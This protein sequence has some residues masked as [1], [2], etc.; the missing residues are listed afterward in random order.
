MTTFTTEDRVRALTEIGISVPSVWSDGKGSD[1]RVQALFNPN[2]E[3]DPHVEYINVQTGQ[4][5][6]CRLPAFKARFTPRPE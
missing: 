1:F 4:V 6:T 5:Y 3:P 2:E